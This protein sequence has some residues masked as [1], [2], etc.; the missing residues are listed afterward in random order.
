[1]SAGPKP[2]PRSRSARPRPAGPPTDVPGSPTAGRGVRAVSRGRLL[3]V[4]LLLVSFVAVGAWVLYLSSWLTLDKVTVEGTTTLAAEDVLDAADVATGG[5][6]ARVD[7]GAISSRVGALGP[8]DSVSLRRAWPDTLVITVDEREPVLVVASADGL[9]VYDASGTEFLNPPAAPFG[10]PVLRATDGE[11]AP[12][13]LEA[14]IDVVGDLPASL[15]DRL[16]DVV[17]P[18]PNAI[19]LNLDDGI[20][21]E[22]GS[23]TD[24]TRKVEVLTELM[25][26]PGRVYIVSAPGVPAIRP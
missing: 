3:L 2:T 20:V 22:W 13:V 26:Q 9:G 19:Q 16:A 10:V 6:L 17:A 14:V 1:M 4:V 15:N 24:N 11:P 23:A 5:P 18:T 7:T 25:K 12:R 8:V 21:V